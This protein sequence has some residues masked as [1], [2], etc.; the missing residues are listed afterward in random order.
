MNV[1]LQNRCDSISAIMVNNGPDIISMQ[2]TCF[3]HPKIWLE[4]D[5]NY[6]VNKTLPPYRKSARETGD[7]L[8]LY[9]LGSL[10]FAIINKELNKK[11]KDLHVNYKTYFLQVK[12][13]EVYGTDSGLAVKANVHGTAKGDLYFTGRLFF[14]SI[15]NT[16]RIKNF[17]FDVSTENVLLQ[18][19]D[20]IFHSRLLE[21]INEKL[22]LPLDSVIK[23]IP[24]LMVS[25][26]EKSKVGD[27]LDVTIKIN[28]IK[29][30]KTVITKNNIQLIVNV[31]ATGSIDLEKKAFTKNMKVLKIRTR[32]KKQT[33]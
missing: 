20:W 14:D 16:I 30:Y 6:I 27:K 8:N 32:P 26:I 22:V 15:N 4:N 3:S 7:N 11:S 18:S 33:N 25:G 5:T 10:P 13:I 21:T 12:G 1:W 28:T 9:I 2:L 23:K 19:A 17:T 29:L 24:L 31:Q